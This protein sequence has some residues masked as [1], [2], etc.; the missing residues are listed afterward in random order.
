LRATHLLARALRDDNHPRTTATARAAVRN[1]CSANS[2]YARLCNAER[3]GLKAIWGRETVVHEGCLAKA[4]LLRCFDG[5]FFPNLTTI[6]LDGCLHEV[7]DAV[8]AAIA[9]HYPHLQRLDL[10]GCLKVTL[11]GWANLFAGCNQLE[12][13]GITGFNAMFVRLVVGLPAIARSKRDYRGGVYDGEWVDRIREGKGKYTYADGA[14]YE[15]D[16]KNDVREGKG[17][18]T[19]ACGSVYEGDWKSDKQEGKG[20]YTSASGDVYEGDWKSG[21]REGKGKYTYASGGDVYEGDWKNNV[22][23]GKGKYT[24]VSGSVYEGDFING[25]WEGKGKITW[26]DGNVYEGDWKNGEKEG[27]G[28]YTYADGNVYEG[29]WKN[30]KVR[31][32]GVDDESQ[33]GRVR[34]RL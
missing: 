31:G 25:E 8:V 9:A 10:S 22:K 27:K 21:E 24:F 20:K 16:W 28:K 2:E 5:A 3:D 18:Y 4:A 11:G 7:D 15:G 34:G 13:V 19:L 23:E 30:D 1:W 32:Q 6:L 26:S 17:K 14:V 12:W 29:D 33:R